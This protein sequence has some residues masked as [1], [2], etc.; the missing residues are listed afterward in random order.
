ME[1]TPLGKRSVPLIVTDP[2]PAVNDAAKKM[3]E[4]AVSERFAAWLVHLY[5][6]AGALTAFLSVRA[7]ID[8]DLRA[9]FFWMAVA[10]II[11][12]TDGWLARRARVADR[13][14]GFSGARLDEIVDYLTFV[15]VPA[16]VLYEAGALPER[17]GL[18]VAAAILLSS[19][20]G[21]GKDD[22]KTSDNFFTGFP[23]YWNIVALYLVAAATPPALNAVVLVALAALVFVRVGYVYPSRTPSL[24]VLT[25]VLALVWGAMMLLTIWRLP[26]ASPGLAAASLF[27][28]VYY[29][30]LSFYL[31][32]Q[33]QSRPRRT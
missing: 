19:A 23:S 10:I 31:H 21:F 30:A 1:T 3:A 7:V 24:R 4:L 14:P 25:V 13:T 6:A 29:A 16:V 27:F 17:G 28:P 8:G 32:A 11:D 18:F 26:A 12:S 22:A 15:F 5:T 20:Y 33:R 9:S 2:T